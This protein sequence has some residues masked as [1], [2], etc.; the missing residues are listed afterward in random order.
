MFR[1]RAISDMDSW[2]GSTHGLGLVQNFEGWSGLGWVGYI[3]IFCFK[4]MAVLAIILVVSV[5]HWF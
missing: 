3:F 4:T 5:S 2:V 1:Y